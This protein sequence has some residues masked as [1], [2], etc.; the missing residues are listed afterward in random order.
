MARIPGRVQGGSPSWSGE[1]GGRAR[2]ESRASSGSAGP[3]RSAPPTGNRTASAC[4]GDRPQGECA[5]RVFSAPAGPAD[6]S[7]KRC[8]LLRRTDPKR[9]RALRALLRSSGTSLGQR[10]ESP[11]HAQPRPEELAPPA[12][13]QRA[14]QCSRQ[15]V[16]EMPGPAS[17]Q[18][19]ERPCAAMTPAARRCSHQPGQE[20]PLAVRQRRASSDRALHVL[21]PPAG[22]PP[23]RAGDSTRRASATGEQRPR[24]ARTRAARWSAAS[25]QRIRHSTLQRKSEALP[26]AAS[27]PRA[28]RRSRQT[29]QKIRRA[30]LQRRPEVHAQGT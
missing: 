28:R 26:R 10:R 4:F 27:T 23:T 9:H 3:R 5:S 13:V 1:C 6:S 17:A 19:A 22:Q 8:R 15:L 12:S 18:T 29:A 16:E 24:A 25:P 11:R 30:V 14:S 7:R 20:T 2:V 21:A